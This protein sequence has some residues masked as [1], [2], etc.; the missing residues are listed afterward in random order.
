MLERRLIYSVIL[1]V[2][3][4]ACCWKSYLQRDIG[5]L[6]Y[7]VLLEVLSTACC[8]KSYLQRDIGRGC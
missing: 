7:S 6:I 2:L 3:S 4:T 5:S 8:W 1:E